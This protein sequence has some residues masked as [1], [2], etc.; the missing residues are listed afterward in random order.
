M[1]V[2]N[3]ID[4]SS[5]DASTASLTA[6]RFAVPPT[7]PAPTDASPRQ[8]SAG[9]HGRQTAQAITM[10]PRIDAV[11]QAKA[12]STRGPSAATARRSHRTTSAKTSGGINE[13]RIMSCTA[14]ISG[15]ARQHPATARAVATT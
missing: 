14:T 13:V 12:T 15:D 4:T 8:A 6:T 11:A 10:P 9:S 3:A 5:G 2:I 7:Q 1:S